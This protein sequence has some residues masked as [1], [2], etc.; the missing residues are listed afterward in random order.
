MSEKLKEPKRKPKYGM[1][2]CV[3]YMYR[4]LWESG[5]SLALMGVLSVPVH[6]AVAAVA[7]YMPSVI[8]RVLETSDRFSVIALVIFGLLLARLILSLGQNVLEE[9]TLTMEFHV[10]MG[11]SYRVEGHCYGRDFFLRYDPNVRE[12]ENRARQ[13]VQNNHTEAVHFPMDFANVAALLLKF[14][15]FGTVISTLN[16]W[17]IL[18]LALCSSL[19]IPLSSWERRRNYETQ[20]RRD[21]LT[22]KLDYLGYRVGR[23]M[24][25]GKDIRLYRMGDYLEQL[26]DKLLGQCRKEKEKVERRSFLVE[27]AGFL[28]V[29][30]RDGAVYAFLIYKA[31]AGELD[32]ARFVLYFTAVTE[33]TD[34]MSG[35]VWWWSRICKGALQ[36]SDFREFLETGGRLNR[37]EGA[38]V[39]K[40]PFS[41]EFRNV[42]YRYPKGEGNVLEDISFKVEAGEKV[43][44]VGLNGAGKT[45]LTKLMC[46]LLLPDRGEVLLDGRELTVYNRD[47]MYTLFGLIPQNYNLLPLSIAENIACTNEPAEVDREKLDRC[48]E[49]AGLK[50]KIDSLPMGA[51]TPLN[52]QVHAEG[53]E[54]SGGEVQKLLLARLLYRAPDCMILDEPTAALD[55]ITEDRMYRKYREMTASATSIFIS[56]RLASTRFCDRILLLDGSRI[57]E[58]GSHEDL[59]A[60]GGKYRELFDIQS[61]YYNDAAHCNAESALG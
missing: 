29:A 24:K 1:F 53:A 33:M 35:I 11:M 61:K 39:P 14:L 26:A 32:A 10:L 28:L 27:L 58:E 4:L 36:V 51:D 18:L 40:R 50:E 16:P 49:L 38:P 52:R 19:T 17:I 41:V 22:K 25:Y 9:N 30:V 15:L 54:L 60:A 8:L 57:A 47:E 42:S 37:G 56:H 20:H 23:N 12:L 45:T 55:P 34:F 31:V 59:M 3:A 46:G 21:N 13:A 2:S 43:A 5:R 44:L 48:L 7:L 6:L